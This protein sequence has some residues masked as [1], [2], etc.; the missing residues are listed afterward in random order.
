MTRRIHPSTSY[1]LHTPVLAVRVES[2]TSWVLGL[3]SR[4]EY[5]SFYTQAISKTSEGEDK[6]INAEDDVAQVGRDS[7]TGHSITRDH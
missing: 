2:S 4:E 1:P 3:D 6:H 7:L 5:G